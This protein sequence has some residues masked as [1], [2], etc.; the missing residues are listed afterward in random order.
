MEILL[1]LCIYH[2]A[3]KFSKPAG[4][5]VRLQYNE[6]Y[7]ILCGNLN[8]KKAF[9]CS[10]LCTI[11]YFVFVFCIIMYIYY[12]VLFILAAVAGQASNI[13]SSQYSSPYLQFNPAVVASVST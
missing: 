6:I 12:F 13:N 1:I 2:P 5:A 3:T 8:L 10:M 9:N 11:Y 7:V 4:L